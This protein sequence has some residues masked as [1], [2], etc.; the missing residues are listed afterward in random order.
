MVYFFHPS[1]GSV[2]RYPFSDHDKDSA[3]VGPVPEIKVQASGNK[4]E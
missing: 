4:M 3:Y 2:T 1:F